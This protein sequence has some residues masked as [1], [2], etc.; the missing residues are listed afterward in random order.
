MIFVVALT[1]GLLLALPAKTH[2]QYVVLRGPA[3][4]KPQPRSREMVAVLRDATADHGRVR[5]RDWST[6]RPPFTAVPPRRSRA[7]TKAALPGRSVV[8]SAPTGERTRSPT[9]VATAA[10]RAGGGA[11]GVGCGVIAVDVAEV[12]KGALFGPLGDP[13]CLPIAVLVTTTGACGVR[14]PQRLRRL[15][16]ASSPDVVRTSG[17]AGPRRHPGGPP[18]GSVGVGSDGHPALSI[19]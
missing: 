10:V 1:D 8:S 6:T 18:P 17:C 12:D 14:T 15:C 2:R 7:W 13:A 19:V 9:L 4:T 16:T 5:R 3:F 11:I